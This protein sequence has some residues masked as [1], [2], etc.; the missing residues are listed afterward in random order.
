MEQIDAKERGGDAD[1]SGAAARVDATAGKENGRGETLSN[2][3]R[4]ESVSNRFKFKFTC[5]LTHAKT[6]I[7]CC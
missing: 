6:K 5:V 2:P 3:K 7:N 4:G 1:V